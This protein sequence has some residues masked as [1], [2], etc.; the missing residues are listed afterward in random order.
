MAYFS[1]FP[2]NFPLFLDYL[3]NFANTGLMKYITIL[4]F[5]LSLC[6]CKT[7]TPK[8]TP[9]TVNLDSPK[10]SVGNFDAQFDPYLNVGKIRTINVK[11]DYYPADDAV[12]LQY[13]MD[14]ITY[15]Q[16]WERDGRAAY[17]AALE[18]YKDDYAQR[19]LS[20]KGSRKTKKQY[21][22][23]DGFLIWQ[24]AA[25]TTRASG[26]TS[27][28][29]GYDI[30]KVSNDKVAFFSIYQLETEFK[31]EKSVDRTTKSKSI[32][33]YLTRAQADELAAFFDH[34]FL[35]NLGI[36]TTE[37]KE[38]ANMDSY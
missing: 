34:D 8:E 32:L 29:L 31:K 3:G 24:A 18:K 37:K 36:G 38:A 30:K 16:F 9:F 20:E 1:I 17:I 4:I 12:C 14:F 5:A 22:R 25:Y 28:E 15:Y 35:K 23:V 6:V 21:G 7:T 10:I 2:S 19:K 11:V 26:N 13:K 33:M 27:F